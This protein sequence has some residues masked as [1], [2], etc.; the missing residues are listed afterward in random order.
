GNRIEIW[1][2]KAYDNLSTDEPDEFAN[3]AEEVMG[4]ANNQE[5]N[6]VS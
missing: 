5:E 2:K 6:G 4:N 1:D 3:L